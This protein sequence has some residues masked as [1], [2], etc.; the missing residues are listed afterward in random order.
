MTSLVSRESAGAHWRYLYLRVQLLHAKA[1]SAFEETR[2]LLSRLTQIVLPTGLLTSILAL[3]V[4]PLFFRRLNGIYALPWFILGKSEVISLLA[5][6]NARKRSNAP[7]IHGSNSV[8]AVPQATKLS[9]M[10]FSP[11]N[12]PVEGGNDIA[13]TVSF[14]AHPLERM[15]SETRQSA[16]TWSQMYQ[17]DPKEV[18]GTVS[19]HQIHVTLGPPCPSYIVLTE[20]TDLSFSVVQP[21]DFPVNNYI[22]NP[23]AFS[24]LVN[25]VCYTMSA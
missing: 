20:E 6:L 14:P 2:D 21:T 15:D 17:R 12:R 24:L 3:I 11:Q 7:V 5:N 25:F 9:T 23:V 8:Q 18:L 4:P 10:V 1:G 16:H 22:I 13:T 19:A